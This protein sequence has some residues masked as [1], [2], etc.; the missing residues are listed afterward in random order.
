MTEPTPPPSTTQPSYAPPP[1]KKK[2]LSP[3]AWVG[4]GCGALVLIGLIVAGIGVMYVG[5]KASD[6]A[7]DFEKNPAMAAAK[8]AVRVNPELELVESDD[9]RGTLTVRNKETGEVLTFDLEEIEQGKL[10]VLTEEGEETSVT[11]R[12]GEG[13]LEIESEQDGTTSRL[14]FG[15]SAGEIP[16]WVP[17]YPGTEPA[18]NFIS[19]T[20]EGTQGMFS[21]TTDDSPDDV[22]SWY[23]DE[24]EDLGME[25]ERSTFSS[26][27][28][29]G[30]LV[31]GEAGGR[32]VNATVANQREG[33]LVTVTFSDKQ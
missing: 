33:T 21:L 5:K 22:L 10:S 29:R 24:I 1:P 14:R 32:Q 11:F 26:A 4:I 13:G 9:E 27:G 20:G 19:A 25:P 30:G 28:S 23:S 31:S 7:G 3:L 8:L 6:L 2:G 16:D 18:S 15:A 17:V 12:S